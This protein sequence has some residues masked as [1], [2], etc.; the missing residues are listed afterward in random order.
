MKG[1]SQ[2]IESLLSKKVS[3]VIFPIDI[4]IFLLKPVNVFLPTLL[5]E[6][7]SLTDMNYLLITSLNLFIT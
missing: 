5:A 4:G 7:L 6:N 2:K 1:L 3:V